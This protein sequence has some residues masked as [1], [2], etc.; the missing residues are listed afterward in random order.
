LPDGDGL[1]L[2]R[3]MSAS[4]SSVASLAFTELIERETPN[5]ALEAGAA[6][7]VDKM[8]SLEEIATEINSLLGK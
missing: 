3:E 1:T 7:L 5:R 8:G 4:N 6:G 2:I